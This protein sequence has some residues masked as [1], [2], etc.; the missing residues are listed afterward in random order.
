MTRNR[1]TIRT[2]SLGQLGLRPAPR[3]A[4]GLDAWIF[5]AAS[6]HPFELDGAVLLCAAEDPDLHLVARHPADPA[7]CRALTEAAGGR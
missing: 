4:P 6:E 3:G 5:R 7:T 2:P 1:T